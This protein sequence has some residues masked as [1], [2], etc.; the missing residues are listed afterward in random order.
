MALLEKGF[1][2][3]LS[4]KKKNQLIC[5]TLLLEITSG[6]SSFGQWIFQGSLKDN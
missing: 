2:T 3:T 6:P 1:K 4:Q 5:K